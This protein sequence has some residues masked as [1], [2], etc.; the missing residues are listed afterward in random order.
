MGIWPV[1]LLGARAEWRIDLDFSEPWD[2]SGVH[3][4][5]LNGGGHWQINR[6]SASA[7]ATVGHEAHFLRSAPLS[8]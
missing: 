4:R 6:H 3:D 2:P 5:F 1:A 7:C 8:T